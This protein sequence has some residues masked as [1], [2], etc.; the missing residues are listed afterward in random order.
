MRKILWLACAALGGCAAVPAE[1]VEHGLVPGRVCDAKDADQFI[2]RA[3]DS[4]TGAAILKATNSAK[5]RWAPPG[6]M[7]TMDFSP[8]RVTVTLGPDRR[9]TKVACG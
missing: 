3:G 1:P 2:G 8:S 4:A 9:I 7:L 5:L 6:T